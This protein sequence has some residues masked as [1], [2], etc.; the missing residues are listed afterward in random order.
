MPY[1]KSQLELI[2]S[3]F[4]INFNQ[5]LKSTFCS[6]LTALILKDLG[7]LDNESKLANNYLPVDFSSQS[8]MPLKLKKYALGNEFTVPPEDENQPN[9]Q[10]SNRGILRNAFG[11]FLSALRFIRSFL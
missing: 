3:I 9:I 6:E 7:L 8:K 4:G 5:D 10:E 1:K 2:Y 11:K